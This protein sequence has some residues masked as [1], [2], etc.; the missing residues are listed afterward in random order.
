MVLG[1]TI[2]AVRDALDTM[3]QASLPDIAAKVNMER[4]TV[5]ATLNLLVRLGLAEKI[6]HSPIRSRKKNGWVTVEY[7][8][9]AS[10]TEVI[11]KED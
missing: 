11:E 2:L 3:G 4:N 1:S 5:R 8:M 7:K 9:I 10:K 6:R